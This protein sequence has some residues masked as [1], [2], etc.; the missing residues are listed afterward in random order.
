MMKFEKVNIRSWTRIRCD[1]V[2]F[3]FIIFFT[4]LSSAAAPT[5]AQKLLK[6]DDGRRLI[7]DIM[8]LADGSIIPENIFEIYDSR[9]LPKV[10]WQ[11]LH[12]HGHSQKD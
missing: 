3:I 2:G 7:P 11:E 6:D 4:A 5:L 8:E 9:I 1:L 10:L 12:Y